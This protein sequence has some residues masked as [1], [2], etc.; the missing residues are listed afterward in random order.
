VAGRFQTWIIPTTR[1]HTNLSQRAVGDTV[2]VEFDVIAK[3]VERLLAPR[4]G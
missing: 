1:T 3:Y 4:L 2:N